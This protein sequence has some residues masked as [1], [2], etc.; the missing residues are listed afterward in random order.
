MHLVTLRRSRIRHEGD[1]I[2]MTHT[3][4]FTSPL[5]IDLSVASLPR[6]IDLDSHPAPRGEA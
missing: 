6:A 1:G 4:H 2:A 3:H 5:L